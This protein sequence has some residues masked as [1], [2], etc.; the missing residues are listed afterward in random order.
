M[1][2]F[3]WLGCILAAGLG[4]CSLYPIVDNVSPLKTENIVLYGRCEVRSVLLD[5]LARRTIIPPEI[6]YVDGE[7]NVVFQTDW[8]KLLQADIKKAKEFEKSRKE[9]SNDQQHRWRYLARLIRVA[10]A[11][12]FDFHITEHNRAGGSAG[13]QMPWATTNV[14][15]V[16][17]AGAVDLTRVGSRVF[18][19][20]DSWEDYLVGPVFKNCV[21]VPWEQRS[22]NFLYP[23]TGTIGVGEVVRTFIDI[24]GQGGAKDNFVDTMTFTTDIGGAVDASVKI[25]PVP[26]Q[27]RLV[28]ATAG[29]AASRVDIHK[30]TVSL[31]FPS[32]RPAPRAITG[33]DRIDGDLNA[34]F[35]RP[36]LWRARYN[37]CVQDARTRETAFKLLRLTDPIV[38]CIG[39]ADQFAPKYGR[40]SIVVTETVPV[41][42]PVSVPVPPA[43]GLS[44]ESAAEQKTFKMVP[45]TRTRVIDNAVRPN[46]IP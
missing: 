36:P 14:L 10:I 45:R 33:V 15:D 26:S 11:Y 16:G 8:Y 7:N 31:A 1:R 30:L 19:T 28:S 39:Y 22:R 17:A 29:I 12:T 6:A 44:Q 2:L 43:A 34:P 25:A 46:V 9:P 18:S 4:G 21:D 24:E 20:E 38:Y 3:N 13:F 35:E 41:R 27:F 32:D 23:L 42:V 37:L 5:H 40:R